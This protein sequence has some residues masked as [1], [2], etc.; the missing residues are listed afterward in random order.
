MEGRDL[1]VKQLFEE[2]ITISIEKYDELQRKIGEL[3]HLKKAY[4]RLFS[5]KFY[6]VDETEE[7][8]DEEELTNE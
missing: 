5:A 6:T 3:E 8:F 2:T 4:P 1:R 7:V